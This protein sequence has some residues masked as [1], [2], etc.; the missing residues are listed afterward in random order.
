MIRI[1]LEK[2]KEFLSKKNIKKKNKELLIQYAERLTNNNLPIIW[3]IRHFSIITDIPYKRIL[4]YIYE[5]EKFYHEIDIPKKRGGVRTLEIPSLEL[6]TLQRDILHE[7]LE[8]INTSEQAYG[9]LKGKSI[10]DNARQHVGKRY[11]LGIDIEN[12]FATINVDRIFKIF[13]YYG[14]TKEVS[15]MLSRIVCKDGYLPQGAPTSPYLSNIVCRKLDRRLLGVAKKYG[16]T[17]TRYA[18]D[19]TF[20][21]EIH[22]DV[23][24]DLI[25]KIIVEEGFCINSNKTRILGN[26]QRQEVTGII[27]NKKVK[28]NKKYKEYLRQQIYYC[29]KYGI[30]SHLEKIGNNVTGF[31]EHMYGIANF[32]KMVEPDEGEKWINKLNEISWYY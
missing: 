16:A 30:D 4:S 27:V 18:D 28:V 8:C 6:K 2:Y 12:F 22:P 11:I 23:Y 21:G 29:N 24:V 14:Y 9:F 5:T 15:F 26:N 25:K 32:I 7:L 20:S 10:V 19:I 31:K 1:D 17:Y 3:D 13:Y